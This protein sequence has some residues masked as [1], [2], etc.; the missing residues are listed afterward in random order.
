VHDWEF[1]K[2]GGQLEIAVPRAIT[3]DESRIGLEL[4]CRGAGLMYVPEHN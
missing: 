2:D 1:E 3:N 4:I